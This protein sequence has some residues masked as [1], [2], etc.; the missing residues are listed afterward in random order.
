MS[1]WSSAAVVF[2]MGLF[3]YM[4]QCCVFKEGTTMITAEGPCDSV[5]MAVRL[6]CRWWYTSG[7]QTENSLVCSIQ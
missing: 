3:M 6:P 1:V 4:M 2:V 7:P 5:A